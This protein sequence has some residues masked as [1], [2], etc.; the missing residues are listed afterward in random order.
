MTG[1]DH[2]TQASNVVR[3]NESQAFLRRQEE[4]RWQRFEIDGTH[5]CTVYSHRKVSL[6]VQGGND[7]DIR[8]LAQMIAELEKKRW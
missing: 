2:G 4:R 5:G 3:M 7:W 1:R 8:R 6:M